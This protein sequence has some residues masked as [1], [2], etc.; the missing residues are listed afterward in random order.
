MRLMLISVDKGDFKVLPVY[1]TL[2]MLDTAGKLL[3]KFTKPKLKE[4]T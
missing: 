2:S 4:A 3:E 1:R